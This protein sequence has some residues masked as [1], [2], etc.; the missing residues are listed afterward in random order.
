MEVANYNHKSPS[1]TVIFFLRFLPLSQRKTIIFSFKSIFYTIF[2]HNMINLL[3]N[4][5]KPSKKKGGKSANIPETT[6]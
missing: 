4:N 6:E 1:N 2:Y 5:I 3:E